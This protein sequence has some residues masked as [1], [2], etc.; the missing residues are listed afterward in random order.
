MNPILDHRL[1][2]VR[3]RGEWIDATLE[4]IDSGW[5]VTFT[6]KGRVLAAWEFETRDQAREAARTRL[7][8]FER[9]GWTEHW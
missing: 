2:R 9:A 7:H 8:E 5:R 4:R 3:R 6:R 1:W